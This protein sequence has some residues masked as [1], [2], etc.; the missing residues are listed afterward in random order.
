MWSSLKRRWCDLARLTQ[1][2]KEEYGKYG[3]ACLGKHRYATEEEAD[4][5]ADRYF[6][7]F[8]E[9]VGSYL[10]HFCGWWHFGH[11]APYV[12]KKQ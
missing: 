10:C 7:R 5:A 2:E 8:H 9:W 6:R 3:H 4:A 11:P 1:E 12:K